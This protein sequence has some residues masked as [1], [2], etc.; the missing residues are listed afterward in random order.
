VLSVAEQEACKDAY[1]GEAARGG[2]HLLPSRAVMRF[3]H[4]LLLSE[5]TRSSWL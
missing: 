4:R 5:G 1:I 2:G 3:G